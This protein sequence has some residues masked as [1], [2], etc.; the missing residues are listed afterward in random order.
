MRCQN[1]NCVGTLQLS[2]T[3]TMECFGKHSILDVWWASQYASE[4]DKLFCCGSMK[5]T[6][7]TLIMNSY[8]EVQYSSYQKVNKG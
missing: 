3:S 7:E 6:H 2:Q 4:L 5:D 1:S 8:V